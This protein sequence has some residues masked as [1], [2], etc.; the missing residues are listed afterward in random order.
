MDFSI[1]LQLGAA[2][3]LATLVG[4]EREHI[5]Q[6]ENY[7][8]FG[9]IRT[10][11][12]I[13]MM[14]ALGQIL[15]EHSPWILPVI[16]FGFFALIVAA[17]ILGGHKSEKAGATSEVAA[18]IVYIVGILCALEY[19]VVA[20][21]VAIA[22]L[23]VLHFKKP[24]HD[25]AKQIKDKELI[26]TIQFIIIA[27][28]ILPLLPNEAYGP[29]N[30]FNPYIIWLMVVFICGIS[31]ASYIAIKIVGEK[32][33][34]A[35]TGFLAGFISSTALTLSFSGESE[36]NKSVVNP[37][38]LAV[39]V[40]STAMFFRVLVEVAVF[41]T[42]L[43]KIVYIPMLAMGITGVSFAFYYWF[44]REPEVEKLR[45]DVL[46]VKS[47]FSLWPALRFAMFFMLILFLSRFGMATLGDKGVY[48]TSFFSGFFDVDAITLSMARAV[49]EDKI[50][51]N[52][53][54]TAITIATMTNT[55]IKAGIMLLFGAR[56][57]SLRVLTAF[58][59]V[60][61]VGGMTLFFL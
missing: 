40:A 57:V 24:L 15:S 21:T 37:Y 33:G 47:P 10:F 4:L 39:I 61:A 25:W 2:F 5:F 23:M 6:T 27:F 43:L 12:L 11:A 30:F 38:V 19:F 34:I 3:V 31:F 49:S 51:V 58:V 28:V 42:D 59:C 56:K 29:Y 13:G 8:G 35:F 52:T 18:I 20:T 7:Q 41:S 32:R 46:A 16:T 60:L 14:G 36:K 22:V 54:A 1:F 48:L 26:S 17:Y 55:S 50:A 45:E 44:K 53:A 9:G